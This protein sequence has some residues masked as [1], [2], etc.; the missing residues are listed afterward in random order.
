MSKSS[1][2]P[3]DIVSD[4]YTKT[5]QSK[6]KEIKQ[7]PPS[8]SPRLYFRIED[9][10][11]TVIGTYNENTRE[12]EAFTYISKHL[13]NKNIPVPKILAENLEKH[14]YLQEDLGENTLY[15][16][17]QKTKSLPDFENRR[18]QLYKK[19]L[20]HLIRIQTEGAKGL[21]FSKCFPRE[22]FDEQSIK[23]D[24]NYFKYSF[25]MPAGIDFDEQALEDD[26]HNFTN[27]LLKAD[28]DFFMFRDFQSRNIM[29]NEQELSFID[30]QGGR[31]GALQYDPASLLYDAK[32]EL[33][34]KLR[35]ELIEL[36][37]DLT[38]K[39]T[40][41]SKNTFF[42]YYRPFVVLRIMQAMGAYGF[43]GLVE[44]KKHFILSIAP[45]QKNLNALLKNADF[46]SNFPELKKVLHKIA[47]SHKL[48]ELSESAK[49]TVS[50]SSFSYKRAVPYDASG[51]G[52]GF[53]FDCRFL[54]NPGRYEKYKTLT[55]KNPKVI[56]FLKENS[57]ADTFAQNCLQLIKPAVENYIQREFA[58]LTIAF[59]C[60]GGQHRSV[61]LSE[62]IAKYLKN[63]YDINITVRHLE[64]DKI[65]NTAT[66]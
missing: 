24:L 31:K 25:L 50:I 21:D 45:A 29:Y 53:V 35:S 14:C 17:L 63:S 37:A 46:L 2:T 57:Q 16:Y 7:L 66:Q 39:H 64:L 15:E 47:E 62:E 6:P 65:Y 59:G 43:R 18:K 51:N 44:N 52:G 42:K 22:K 33:P 1:Q 61:Y 9:S 49:L 11:R 3:L 4:L 20:E 28:S 30:Y 56:R 19:V 27:F 32:A 41:I 38:E 58:N 12:N 60:T 34:E 13:K 23:W 10:G 26:F 36:Y 5:F 40:G 48:T 8:G 55:G 54:N